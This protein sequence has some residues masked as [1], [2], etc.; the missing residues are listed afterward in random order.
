MA[1]KILIG[2]EDT[3]PALLAKQKASWEKL[4]KSSD[5]FGKSVAKAERTAVSYGKSLVKQNR[6]AEQAL[7]DRVSAVQLAA[8]K[9][10][11]TQQEKV[12]TIR[13]LIAKHREEGEAAKAAAL[14]ATDAYKRQ[15]T[16][17]DA[18]VRKVGQLKK[19]NKSLDKQYDDLRTSITAAFDA[20]KISADDYKTSLAQLDKEQKE[21]GKNTGKSL[22]MKEQITSAIAS[23]GVI[24]S[25][26]RAVK[27]SV[28]EYNASKERAMNETER[29]AAVRQALGSLTDV[30][31]SKLESASDELA[32]DPTLGL[33]RVESRELTFAGESGGFDP[34]IPAELDAAF[35]VELGQQVAGGFRQQFARENLS[36]ENAIDTVA[37]A[38][39]KS[40]FKPAQFL[41]QVQKAAQGAE[42]LNASSSD[43]SAVVATMVGIDGNE[44]G[45]RLKSFQE[46]VA[47][48]GL[49]ELKGLDLIPLIETLKDDAALRKKALGNNQLVNTFFKGASTRID[50]FKEI[51]ALIERAQTDKF[52]PVRDRVDEI[53]DP[54]TTTG[55]IEISRR[56]SVAAEQSRLIAE[57]NKFAKDGFNSL[58]IREEE[59]TK[60]INQGGSSFSRGIANAAAYTVSG[61]TS[62]ETSIRDAS[63]YASAIAKGISLDT[64]GITSLQESEASKSLF[65]Q[66]KLLESLERATN[67][68]NAL[69]E[70]QNQLLR[71]TKEQQF[72]GNSR[73]LSIPGVDR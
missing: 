62:D 3:I 65:T 60:Q 59:A 39:A 30:P 42:V 24:G 40:L 51:D 32:T 44:T 22:N 43:V 23:I 14:K 72:G 47:A 19:A 66:T 45:T 13:K 73:P 68:Q 18:G 56:K 16:E 70:E 20:G 48:S 12:D 57:E 69:S 46:T 26:W 49:K 61:F 37:I 31:F 35:A 15:A 67:R 52:S 54:T 27:M 17:I 6:S 34:R 29:L 4:E 5:D 1:V 10:E 11:I 41:P 7:K 36:E 25:A 21:L 53:L 64:G 71:D 55:R 28:D 2:G 63:R 38:A 33:T 9:E 58:R 8:K 50:K